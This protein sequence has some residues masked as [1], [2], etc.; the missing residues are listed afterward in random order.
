MIEQR[1]SQ[2][3]QLRLPLRILRSGSTTLSGAGETLNVGSRGVLF[4]ANQR[5]EIGASIEYAI[6]LPPAPG[7]SDGS[8]LR[9]LGKVLRYEGS[10]EV[11]DSRAKQ[12]VMAATI[13]RHE[14]LRQ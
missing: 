11:P 10:T 2:R 13:E 3:F 9:C 14:F 7:S 1:K 4:T 8:G 5:L 12:Y 6:T